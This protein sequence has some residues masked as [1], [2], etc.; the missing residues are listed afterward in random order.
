MNRVAKFEKVSW[1]EFLKDWIDTFPEMAKY[2]KVEY[3]HVI[4]DVYDNIRLPERK[5]K[6]SAGYDFCCPC[7]LTLRP[8]ETVKIPTGIRVCIEEGWVL[9][10]YPRSSMGFKY[11]LQLDNTVG[12]IDS[13]YYNAKNE[14]HIFFKITNDSKENVENKVLEISNEDTFVQGIFIPFG[15]TTDDEADGIRVGG[16][17]STTKK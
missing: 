17:G 2:G 4:K 5:T 7:D 14:G 16:I 3:E 10:C 1:E 11:R 12:I 8:G 9:K 6:G 13:D 15:I